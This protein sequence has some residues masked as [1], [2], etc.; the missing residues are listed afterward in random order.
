MQSTGYP[1]LQHICRQTVYQQ[2][3]KIC[4]QLFYVRAINKITTRYDTISAHLGLPP[5][6]KGGKEY[7][8]NNSGTTTTMHVTSDVVVCIRSWQRAQKERV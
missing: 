5:S 7:Y 2:D 6:L 4:Q 3:R 1:Y 8:V